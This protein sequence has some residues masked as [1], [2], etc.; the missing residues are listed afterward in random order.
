MK[1]SF[2]REKWLPFL[3]LLVLA[4]PFV[5]AAIFLF[6]KHQWAQQQLQQIE[7]RYARLLG[8]EASSSELLKA[9]AQAQ[10]LIA[11]AAYASGQDVSQAGNDAQQRIRS[12]FTTAGLNIVSSQVLAAKE[13]QDFDRI[14][15]SVRSEG[16]L[17]A[18]QAALMGLADQ[19]PLLFVESFN[20]QAIGAVRAEVPQNLAI[21]FNFYVLRA[22]P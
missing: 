9:Q 14:P 11:K 21:Q 13:E 16:K 20:I 6:Q 3:C 8:L 5:V 15:L 1:N 4:L 2:N 7:P 19:A 10:T 18:L 17:S 22:R 12:I